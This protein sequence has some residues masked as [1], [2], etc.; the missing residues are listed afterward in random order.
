MC[1][2][3]AGSATVRNRLNIPADDFRQSIQSFMATYHNCTLDTDL[4]HHLRF[5]K[6]EAT[7]S[8]V[9][10]VVSLLRFEHVSSA[11][12]IAT[13]GLTMD[14]CIDR[15]C[16]E[17]LPEGGEIRVSIGSR[18][19]GQTCYANYMAKDRSAII[20]DVSRI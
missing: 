20:V 19:Q 11:P 9:M 17:H 13:A 18:R 3:D 15:V 5:L 8:T 7:C 14:A 12:A 6:K 1:Q 4:K 2:V 10:L 16:R